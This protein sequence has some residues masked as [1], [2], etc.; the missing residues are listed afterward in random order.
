MAGDCV[1]QVS[2]RSQSTEHERSPI[3]CRSRSQSTERNHSP[4]GH[5][6][7]T[8]RDYSVRAATPGLKIYIS[9]LPGG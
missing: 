3:P 6:L 1:M 7:S 8:E 4:A 2:N 5:H 9:F